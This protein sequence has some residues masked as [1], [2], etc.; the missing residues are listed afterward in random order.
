MISEHRFASTYASV[1]RSITPL[2]D[3]YWKTH[4]QLIN[5]VARPVQSRSPKEIRGLVNELAFVAFCE[6]AAA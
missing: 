4:N 1:W 2:S 6:V 5:R 3:G